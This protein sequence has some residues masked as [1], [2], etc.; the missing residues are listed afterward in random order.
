MDEVPVVQT[1][2]WGASVAADAAPATSP[3]PVAARGCETV[4][5][6]DACDAIDPVPVRPSTT[7]R[8]LRL[9]ALIGELSARD[10]HTAAVAVF[11]ECS[12]TAARNYLNE[13]L[14]ASVISWRRS[15]DPSMRSGYRLN[16]DTGLVQ[17]F[18][19]GLTL[20]RIANM[21]RESKPAT[22]AQSFGPRHFH[23][24]ADDR[25]LGVRATH[26][27]VRRDP[28]VAALFGNESQ[29]KDSVA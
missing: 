19:A 20:P 2:C 13:L 14:E 21:K 10:M 25:F 1:S 15:P 7:R 22:E 24:I 18:L 6:N 8:H 27:L 28:L 23:I 17:N 3:E 4:G 5:K 26:V 9:R 11:L 29:R 12:H 16:G